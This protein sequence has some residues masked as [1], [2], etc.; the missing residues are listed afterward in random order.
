MAP[1]AHPTWLSGADA[2]GT[3]VASGATSMWA[4]DG[5]D[6][7]KFGRSAGAAALAGAGVAAVADTPQLR[8]PAAGTGQPQ[9]KR[10]MRTLSTSPMPA[11]QAMTEVP[12]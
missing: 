4:S 2:I 3:C 5:Q 7:E 12:P 8:S 11:K 9:P 6:S 10:C 1:S